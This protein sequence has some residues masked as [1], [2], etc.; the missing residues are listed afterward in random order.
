M[1]KRGRIGIPLFAWLSSFSGRCGDGGGCGGTRSA[2]SP[3]WPSAASGT[4][5]ISGALAGVRG[6]EIPKTLFPKR[7]FAGNRPN[8]ISRMR[9][10]KFSGGWVPQKYVDQPPTRQQR[11]FVCDWIGN[12]AL[13]EHGIPAVYRHPS[14]AAPSHSPVPPSSISPGEAW[15]G[16]AGVGSGSAAVTILATEH[17]GPPNACPTHADQFRGSG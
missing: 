17:P 6:G 1:P 2:L 4:Q 16:L 10:P 12:A 13:V 11:R 14:R 9:Y 5:L 7:A 3:R 8:G 15:L